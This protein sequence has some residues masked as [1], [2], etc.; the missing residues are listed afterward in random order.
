MR[1]YRL[2]VAW[3][4]IGL[5]T[6]PMSAHAVLLNRGGGMAYDSVLNITWLRNA[7]QGAGS[8]YDNGEHANDGRMT[9]GNAVAWADNLVYRGFDDWRL[10]TVGP[11]G[12]AFNYDFSNNGTTDL[13][14]GNTSPNSEL[15]YMYYV[16]LGNKGWC[17]PNDGDPGGCVEQGGWGFYNTGP[18]RNTQGGLSYWSGTEYAPRANW[19]WGFKTSDGLQAGDGKANEFYAWAV[20][21]GDVS[22][23]PTP[24]PTTAWLLLA[25]LAGVLVSR[26]AGRSLIR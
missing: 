26:R 21:P 7:N 5:L 18:F 15:A 24:E 22:F 8:D 23:V 3:L 6:A 14:Y 9:W 20:R 4:S 11:V 12:A 10:P 19:A 13:G 17:T 16:S 1:K 2:I 25:G